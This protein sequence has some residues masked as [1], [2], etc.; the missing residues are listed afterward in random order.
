MADYYR[1]IHLFFLKG[2]AGSELDSSKQMLE[3]FNDLSWKSNFFEKLTYMFYSNY[4][5]RQE[6]P[7]L[8][9]DDQ[10]NVRVHE[11]WFQPFPQNVVF[12]RSG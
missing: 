11:P 7:G 9:Q 4:T 2:E 10:L 5:V 1:Q 3:K 12:V 8:V 6:H